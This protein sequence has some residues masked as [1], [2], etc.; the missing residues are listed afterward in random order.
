MLLDPICGS[1]SRRAFAA[2]APSD[3]INGDVKLSL[4]LG[5]RQLE[6][7]GDRR[8]TTAYYRDF[9]WFLTTHK[10]FANSKYA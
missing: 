10:F 4:M 2:E 3:L 8:A 7:R 1:A 9:D 6:G 5:P